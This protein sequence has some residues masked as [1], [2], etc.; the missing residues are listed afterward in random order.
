MHNNVSD[1]LTLEQIKN[2]RNILCGLVG[3]Y[4]RFMSDEQIQAY[5]DKMQSG[6]NRKKSKAQ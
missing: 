5:R 3:P 2:W 6:L 4:A 1:K